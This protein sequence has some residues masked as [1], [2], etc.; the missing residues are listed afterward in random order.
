MIKIVIGTEKNQY[1]AQKVLEY[2]IRSH[3]SAE[4]DIR[5]VTQTQKRVGGTKFGF[6]RFLVPSIFDYEGTAIYLDADQ[7][8]LTDIQELANSLKPES[9]LALVSNLEGYF[10][11][12]PVPQRKETSVMVMNCAKLKHWNP[13]TIFNNVVPNDS[14]LEPGQIH[15]RDF[16]WL[17]WMDDREIQ[18]LE[19]TWNHFNILREDTK[20]LHFSHVASQPWKK[21]DHPLSKF[22]GQWLR[23]TIRAGYLKRRELWEAIAERDVH[24]YYL[25]YLIW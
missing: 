7:I 20:L 16:M 14:S 10:G 19:P 11:G 2:S 9:T 24:R 22:W 25:R 3:T 17:K 6:V 18:E 5:F 13:E 21:P 15:Y 4:V 1:L 12:K 8:V 23:K